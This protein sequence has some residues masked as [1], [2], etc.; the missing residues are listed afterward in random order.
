M[1]WRGCLSPLP[2][3]V[4]FGKNPSFA[5]A[6]PGSLQVNRLRPG[7]LGVSGV[8]AGGD[9]VDLL[10][11]S[12]ERG[13]Q[14]LAS[15]S[16]LGRSG[17]LA[18]PLS[19]GG[20]MQGCFP[21]RRQ[22]RGTCVVTVAG[23]SLWP[24]VAAALGF[25]VA[26][27][28]APEATWRGAY[29]DLMSEFSPGATQVVLS[30]WLPTHAGQWGPTWGA[31]TR[32]W[33]A[34]GSPCRALLSQSICCRPAGE[35]DGCTTAAWELGLFVPRELGRDEPVPTR[36]SP[37]PP[38]TFPGRDELDPELDPSDGTAQDTPGIQEERSS[39]VTHGM[40]GHDLLSGHA[41]RQHVDEML[42][43]IGVKWCRGTKAGR[44]TPAAPPPVFHLVSSQ[45]CRGVLT[46]HE[47]DFEPEERKEEEERG[48]RGRHEFKV[49][50]T[51]RLGRVRGLAA[52]D[53]GPRS[54]VLSTHTRREL[55]PVGRPSSFTPSGIVAGITTSIG[56]Q[57]LSGRRPTGVPEASAVPSGR[58]IAS[59]DEV[60]GRQVSGTVVG[61]DIQHLRTR[62]P[63][64]PAWEQGLTRDWEHWVRNCMGLRDN[65]L[66]GAPKL[67][68]SLRATSL[69]RFCGSC[70]K[71]SLLDSTRRAMFRRQGDEPQ[72]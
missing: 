29:A 30:K 58:R 18:H 27:I 11:E 23:P 19:L 70:G 16:W 6:T 4:G 42:R 65:L 32:V 10:L 48:A 43:S 47:P 72:G 40:A 31:G 52:S 61:V 1:G 59:G 39:G 51:A 20:V 49:Y 57:P 53:V 12:Q 38:A 13:S 55:G 21:L 67:S 33:F 68:P 26:T 62:G 25:R 22:P 69:T 41:L 54:E 15:P 50:P 3:R 35:L 36:P 14:P 60:Q 64:Q 56:M 24:F 45:V 71:S 2:G 8:G 37:G 7:R 17:V 28:E 34:S 63:D 44:S 9:G 46:D 66:C 5:L